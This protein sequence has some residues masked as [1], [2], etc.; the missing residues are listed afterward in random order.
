MAMATGPA[1]TPEILSDSEISNKII[2]SARDLEN[3]RILEGIPDFQ[4]CKQSFQY[5]KGENTD[6]LRQRS[7]QQ[8][9]QCFKDA[10]V[11]KNSPEEIGQIADKL[12]LQAY[13]LIPSKSVQEITKYLSNKMYKSLT[14][15]DYEENDVKKRIESLKFNKNKKI[16]DQKQFIQ[17]Y[18]SQVAKNILSEVT[19]F[20]FEDLRLNGTA[21]NDSFA[22]HWATYMPT[23][24]F[25]EAVAAPVGSS[26]SAPGVRDNGTPFIK[27]AASQSREDKD[28]AYQNIINTTFPGT[29][30]PA[31]I[32][33]SFFFFCG[34]QI[35][36]LCTAFEGRQTS[37]GTTPADPDK[38]GSR[39]CLTKSRLVSYKKALKASDLIIA[40][41]NAN[42]GGNA[43]R[44]LDDPNAVVKA[45]GNG[46][47][48]TEKSLNEISNNASIDFFTATES[49]DT[50]KA[51]NCINS[52]AAACDDFVIVD[53]SREKIQY[54]V[55]IEYSAKREAEMARVRALVRGDRQPLLV[56]LK[57]NGYMKLADDIEKSGS[58]PANFDQEIGKIWE[59]RKIALQ[60]EIQ[61]R[62]GSRQMTEAEAAAPASGGVTA[63][64]TNAKANATETLN[65]RAR[66]A[67]V[68]FF[69][70]II[71]SN[72][73][74]IEAGTNREV[75]RNTQALDNELN[76]L[77][78]QVDS[79]IFQSLQR[80]GADGDNSSGGQNRGP[81]GREEISDV[82]FLDQFLGGPE[83]PQPGAQ[84]SGNR[85]TNGN[86][87]GR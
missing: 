70:N 14:G 2:S 13:K 1:S 75:G 86:G 7:A 83:T 51:Q 85:N 6:A 84:G 52:G 58:I 60:E 38:T 61:S 57:T 78:G 5:Q 25:D 54:N 29:I 3:Q 34:K 19:R 56:Y 39:A 66:L 69:N 72:L 30:P 48:R 45:F 55:E 42:G 73:R 63:K 46:Q 68:I 64:I 43:F 40:D 53:D 26:T 18:K 36:S 71:S 21:S 28:T 9:T 44:L 77:N 74:L 11:G 15:I 27:G 76:S 12:N 62:L 8:A 80:P 16:V 32:L 22:D 47:D 79:S 10:L 20:C 35:N 49:E 82:S 17:L 81:T 33:S 59:A 4:N 31:G 23:G 87:S 24:N 50:Q 67:R 41:F 65:E 37:N